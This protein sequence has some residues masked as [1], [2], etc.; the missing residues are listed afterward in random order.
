MRVSLQGRVEKIRHVILNAIMC[1][2]IHIQVNHN[3]LG[4]E[5]PV[6]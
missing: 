4:C 6:R 2:I 5:Q 3:S 1:I